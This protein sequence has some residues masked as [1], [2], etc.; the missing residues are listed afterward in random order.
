MLSI[1]YSSKAEHPFS[2]ADLALLLEQSRENNAELD[3]S[4]MLLYRQGRFLQ[5]LEGEDAPLRDKMAVIARDPRHTEVRTLLDEPIDHRF[6]GQWTMRYEHV[7]DDD[8]STIPGYRQ[9]FD[10]LER[11]ATESGTIPA[12][13][14]L[15]RWFQQPSTPRSA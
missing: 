2:D 3:I 11:D 6:F 10:D 5:V 1:V 4:G 15:I 9:S 8:A 13:R 12:V 14:E 7:S